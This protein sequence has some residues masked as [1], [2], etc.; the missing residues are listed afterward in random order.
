MLLPGI[1][2]HTP[3]ADRSFCINVCFCCPSVRTH[4]WSTVW[5]TDLHLWLTRTFLSLT[6]SN[7][8]MTNLA[9]HPPD[10]R[11]LMWHGQTETIHDPFLNSLCGLLS[12]RDVQYL[13]M[14]F[15]WIIC[16]VVCVKRNHGYTIMCIQ[17]LIY[18]P[19]FFLSQTIWKHQLLTNIMFD[20]AARCKNTREK[21]LTDLQF[22]KTYH[23]I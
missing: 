20:D 8:E 22:F 14:H 21:P 10:R 5:L 11:L 19:I 13:F 3:P 18:K 15:I 9:M 7:I 12:I 4:V 6:S 1:M 17:F 2:T 23:T 16:V